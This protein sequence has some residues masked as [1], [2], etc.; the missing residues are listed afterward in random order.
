M[1][2]LILLF[3]LSIP[4]I[5]YAC[6]HNPYATNYNDQINDNFDYVICL[7]NEQNQL[8]NNLVDSVNEL[9]MR[10]MQVEQTGSSSD[11][12]K[13]RLDEIAKDLR[14]LEGRTVEIETALQKQT[15]K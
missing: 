6:M 14:S 3:V 5:S 15:L 1:R 9:N 11:T 13:I 4:T 8:I 10:L 12:L 7:H 2:S